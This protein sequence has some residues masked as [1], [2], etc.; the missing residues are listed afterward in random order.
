MVTVCAMPH[1]REY[2]G[3]IVKLAAVYIPAI[4]TPTTLNIL[5]GTKHSQ[6]IQNKNC[7]AI[8]FVCIYK[9]VISNLFLSNWRLPKVRRVVKVSL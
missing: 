7:R 8:E 4:A 5:I 6:L 2:I 3:S 9:S 1:V